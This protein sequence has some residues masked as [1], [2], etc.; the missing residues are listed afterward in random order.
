MRNKSG[1]MKDEKGQILIWVI[2]LMMLAA[3]VIPPFVASA[4]SGVHTSQVRQER[5]QE[6]YAADTGIEDALKWIVS[7]GE[8]QRPD[9]NDPNGNS[10]FPPGNSTDA[11]PAEYRLS[12]WSDATLQW[13]PRL[14]NN[15]WVDIRVERD[16]SEPLGNYTY[17]VYSNATNQDTGTN[18]KVQVHCTVEEGTI[19]G[20]YV[21]GDWYIKNPNCVI[22]N[23]FYYAIGSLS[24]GAVLNSKQGDI[25][26]DIFVNGTTNLIGGKNTVNG[27]VYS[28]GDL[29]LE[30]ASVIKENAY[31]KGDIFMYNSA[32]I[33]Q[34]AVGNKSITLSGSNGIWGNAYAQIDI[35][36]D[37]GY[38]NGNA[39]AN[40]DVNVSSVIYQ[41]A[42]ANNDINVNGGRIEGWAKYLNSLNI[43]GGGFVGNSEQ[44]AQ[45]VF[46][47]QPILPQIA[48]AQN[49]DAAYWGNASTYGDTLGP[50]TIQGKDPVSLGPCVVDGDL[51]VK[52]N[53]KLILT[54][55]VYVK[56]TVTLAPGG[57]ISTVSGTPETPVALVATGDITLKSNIIVQAG[58]VLPLIM[59]VNGS[60][61]CWAGCTIEAALY[62]P[63]ASGPPGGRIFLKN[64]CYVNGAVVAQ[65]VAPEQGKE[66]KYTIVY[67]EAVLDI[68]GLPYATIEEPC[69]PEWT[70]DCS[71]E[72]D[73]QIPTPWVDVDSYIVLEE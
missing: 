33:E 23:P 54:G 48:P 73:T 62:A 58:E 27:N 65:Q 47:P 37:S 35:N 8:I 51:E 71:Q 18:V 10:T 69:E 70:R 3:L 61:T 39:S 22:E 32:R 63:G 56:G 7:N 26:G 55:T 4:W 60:I 34:N 50:Q 64:G 20:A 14:V 5:M 72:P 57:N 59:S 28:L 16:V 15:C 66:A 52:N 49:P 2:A 36:V 12:D 11:E 31:V 44:L 46:V 38:I 1:L 6:L 43:S 13:I 17:F 25:E 67:N 42:F 68:Q 30:E 24:G 45:P 29:T 40:H 53:A 9:L 19:P 41:S 21:C